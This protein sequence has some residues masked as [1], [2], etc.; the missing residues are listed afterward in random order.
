GRAIVTALL[1]ASL[2]LSAGAWLT[3]YADRIAV[4]A[5]VFAFFF[6]SLLGSRTLIYASARLLRRRGFD[7]RRVCV[8]GSW[9]T[10]EEL[11][12]RFRSNPQWGLTVSYVGVGLRQQREFLRYPER[13]PLGLS[14]DQVLEREVLDEIIIALPPAEAADEGETIR[15]FEQYGVIGRLMFPSNPVAAERERLEAYCGEIA[16]PVGRK[17]G[18]E[19]ALAV[20]RLVDL[21]LSTFA[22]I[23]LAPLLALIA[24]LVKLSSPGPVIFRQKRIG[25]NGRPFQ[26]LKFRTMISNAADLLPTYAH[27]NIMAGPAFKDPN[28]P[29]ITPIGRVLRRFSLDELPQLV[30]IL[31]NEMSLVGPRPLPVHEAEQITGELRRRFRMKPGLT[32]FWQVSGRNEVRFSRWMSYDLEYVDRWSLWVDTK[33]ILKTIPVVFTGRGAY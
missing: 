17:S 29:R 2:F 9:E 30:N 5:R 6:A 18:D 1:V 32:C 28:D 33:L 22:L 15:T 8:I 23:V 21:T 3:G 7:P 14:L 4:L 26:M 31:K 20:K 16:V 25:L 19:A 13:A 12:K 11:A 27:R 24:I 10:A